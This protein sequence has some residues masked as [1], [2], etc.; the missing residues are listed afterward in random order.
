MC[1]II[2]NPGMN[3]VQVNVDQQLVEVALI[4]YELGSVPALPQRPIHPLSNV[5][6]S[7]YALLKTSHGPIQRDPTGPDCQVIVIRHQAPR[8][9]RQPITLRNVAKQVDECGSLR[10]LVEDS[11]T[12][13]NPVVHVV[14]PALDKNS[15]RPRHI[16]CL[17][18][19]RS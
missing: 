5:Y 6:A 7:S 2:N 9:D 15:M 11:L 19:N 10:P 4:A 13:T 8:E 18:R 14:H 1:W 16:L 12:S 3:R 17:A